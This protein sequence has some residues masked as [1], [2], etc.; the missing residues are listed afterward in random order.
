MKNWNCDN[1]KCTSATGEIRVLPTG[2]ESNALLCRS[3]FE[4]EMNF[5]RERNRKLAKECQFKLPAWDDLKVY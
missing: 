1:D 2:G 5:R 3:C 4:Y